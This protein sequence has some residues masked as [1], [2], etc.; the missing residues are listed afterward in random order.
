MILR[1]R[2]T[3][4]LMWCS[5]VIACEDPPSSSAAPSPALPSPTAKAQLTSAPEGPASL[6]PKSHKALNAA[7]LSP[8]EVQD[9]CTSICT[10]TSSLECV[11]EH[12]CVSGC[13]ETFGLPA[14]RGEFGAMLNCTEQTP[15]DGFVCDDAPT[16]VLKDGYCEAEQGRAARCVEQLMRTGQPQL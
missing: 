7:G 4:I 5:A 1:F 15:V 2:D 3:Q 12:P 6:E 13:L 14:C 10:K 16:P 9:K 11:K 8:Q